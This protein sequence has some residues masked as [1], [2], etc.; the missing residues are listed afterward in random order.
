[1]A[2]E[3]FAAIKGGDKAVVEALLDRDHALVDARDEKGLSPILTA[4]YHGKNDIATAILRRGPKLTLFEAAAAGD[5]ARVREIIGRDR[6][7]ANAVA[8]DGYSALGLAAFFRRGEVLRN[9]LD[10]GADPSRASLQGGFTPL[11]SAVATDAA[12]VDVEIVRMLLDKGADP[13]AKSQSGSTPLHTVAFTGD[14]ASLDHLLKHRAD[15]GIK[16]NEGKTAADVARERGNQEIVDLLVA[17]A[18]T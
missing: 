2:T 7:Q 15:P 14:R 18:R 8:P 11:H 12:S 9:L 17:R 16:N 1:M 6:G 10:A 5:A 13:N 4:L 3:L